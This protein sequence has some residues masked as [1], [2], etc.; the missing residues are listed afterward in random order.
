M[1]ETKEIFVVRCP[2]NKRDRETLEKLIV[3]NVEKGTKIITDGW[4]AYKRLNTLGYEWDWVNHSKK[5]VK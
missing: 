5:F 2:K 3:E 4:A 1:R